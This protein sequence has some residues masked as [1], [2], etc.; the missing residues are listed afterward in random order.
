VNHLL[1]LER[2]LKKSFE[3]ENTKTGEM[4]ASILEVNK[5]ILAVL[6]SARRSSR[7]EDSLSELKDHMAELQFA[8]GALA[9]NRKTE[10]ERNQKI[11][12]LVER[13]ARR[14][15]PDDSFTGNIVRFGGTTA[16]GRA[17]RAP[18]GDDVYEVVPGRDGAYTLFPGGPRAHRADVRETGRRE[19]D[20]DG[21]FARIMRMLRG[22][23]TQ[24]DA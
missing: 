20:G 10:T 9:A 3:S 18:G 23:S 8:I 5:R 19:N 15:L 2:L 7:D 13:I 1:L 21:F 4:C 12:D 16:A 11:L 14:E 17:P 6:S 24:D 22:R